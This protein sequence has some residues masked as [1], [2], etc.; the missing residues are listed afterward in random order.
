MSPQVVKLLEDAWLASSLHLGSNRVRSGTI[1]LALLDNEALLGLVMESCPPLLDIPRE[2]FREDLR[3]LVRETAEAK[4]DFGAGQ[5]SNTAASSS[6]TTSKSKAA[7]SK[8]KASTNRL[9]SALAFSPS[10]QALVALY[11]TDLVDISD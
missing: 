8:G 1:L 4:E 7:G 2:Q 6:K 9:A 5:A 11:L 10:G 3:E